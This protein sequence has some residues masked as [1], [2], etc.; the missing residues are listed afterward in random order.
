MLLA[1]FSYLKTQEVSTV[2]Y[3]E[4]E[5]EL[6]KQYS[7]FLI[8]GILAFILVLTNCSLQP[9]PSSLSVYFGPSS[10]KSLLSKSMVS[11][12]T[13]AKTSAS[14][15]DVAASEQGQA[16]AY[17]D[18][19]SIHDVGP[20][21]GTDL[22]TLTWPTTTPTTTSHLTFLA[23]LELYDTEDDF[24]NFS[25]SNNGNLSTYP[26]SF[27]FAS[28]SGTTL[29]GTGTLKDTTYPAGY[30]EITGMST[31]ESSVGPQPIPANFFYPGQPQ[32]NQVII[33]FGD[34]LADAQALYTEESTVNPLVKTGSPGSPGPVC[35]CIAVPGMT[36]INGSSGTTTAT[37]GI[38]TAAILDQDSDL[39]NGWWN[40]VSFIHN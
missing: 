36:A 21:E 25:G 38:N 31:S 11:A 35:I 10:S 1:F 29:I 5:E 37:F 2:I 26:I 28:S 6:M 12:K 9:S 8:Y 33:F 19:V 34:T 3:D 30:I 16:M 17:D 18:T 22:S 23:L 7:K 14:L 4:L 24:V 39:T 27:D 15:N 40:N 20:G 32:A 13:S